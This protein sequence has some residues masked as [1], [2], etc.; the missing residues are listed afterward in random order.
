M[1][2]NKK[3]IQG[4]YTP[5]NPKKYTGSVPIIYRSSLELKSFRYLDN[6]PNILSWGSESVVIPYVSPKDGRVHRYFVDLVA[7]LKD[8]TGIIKKILIEV[9]PENQTKP[10]KFSIKKKPQTVL[11]EKIQ[12][13]V[14]L[15]KWEA[16]RKWSKEKGYTFLIL[17][18][19]HLI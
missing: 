5:T 2:K 6:N 16:A 18:E 15:S 10:P 1:K 11:Y 13:A 17:N 12:Y 3:Y 4:I 14:N 19:K 7:S 8:R 9:K